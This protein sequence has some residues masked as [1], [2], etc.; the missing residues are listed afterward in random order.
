MDNMEIIKVH[1]DG[2]LMDYD[3][4]EWYRDNITYTIG[5]VNRLGPN[6]WKL[7]IYISS[8]NDM[9]SYNIET[10]FRE[11]F[12]RP[13]KCTLEITSAEYARL[14]DIAQRCD[15]KLNVKSIEE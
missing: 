4:Y 3:G 10:A 8:E 9:D 12:L 13:T 11:E 2:D 7:G 6:F 15:L 5:F 14:M 1:Y